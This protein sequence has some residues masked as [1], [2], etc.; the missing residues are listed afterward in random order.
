VPFDAER[1]SSR[2]FGVECAASFTFVAK[3]AD[4]GPFSASPAI[5]NR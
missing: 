3:V 4:K 1:A 2:T 5:S